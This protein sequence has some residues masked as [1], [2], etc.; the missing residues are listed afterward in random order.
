MQKEHRPL[1]WFQS[2]HLWTN[3][4][5]VASRYAVMLSITAAAIIVMLMVSGSWW[6]DKDENG[7]KAKDPS[8]NI[9]NLSVVAVEDITPITTSLPSRILASF[10][11][12]NDTR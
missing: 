4:A 11:L 3:A 10:A 5:K 8:D 1:R 2:T 6:G 7:A 9:F 12:L